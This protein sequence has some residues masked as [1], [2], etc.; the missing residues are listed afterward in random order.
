MPRNSAWGQANSSLAAWLA[1][2]MVPSRA[3][4]AMASRHSSNSSRYSS[5]LS[6]LPCCRLIQ[7]G[8]T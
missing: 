6:S 5:A 3:M 7:W 1:S 8:T 2:R 4:I